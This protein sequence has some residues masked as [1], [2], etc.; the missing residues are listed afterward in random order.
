[1]KSK[2]FISLMA[3][4]ALFAFSACGTDEPV[5]DSSKLLQESI[6]NV[7][8]LKSFKYKADFKAE[9]TDSETKNKVNLDM[10]LNGAVS[11]QDASKTGTEFTVVAKVDDNSEN[12][13]F[14][15]SAKFFTEDIY[16]KL[17]ALPEVPNFPV[18]GLKGL[19]G[20]WWKI[21]A[22]D[23]GEV[24][25]VQK[26]EGIGVPY[27]KLDERGKKERDLILSSKFFKDIEYKSTENLEGLNVYEYTFVVDGNGVY[28]YVYELAKLDGQE[29]DAGL[30]EVKAM[31]TDAVVNGTIFVDVNSKTMVKMDLVLDAKK[32]K[33]SQ[34]NSMNLSLSLTDLNKPFN[35]ETPT[36]F[37]VFD[38]GKFLGS[39]LGSGMTSDVSV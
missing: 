8:N 32:S 1:M 9:V 5:P 30:K 20:K 12:Y 7:Y 16:L 22:A 37:E 4:S 26:M 29:K 11:G 35:V 14:D 6:Y 18:D 13:R 3:L 28:K 27:D 33:A 23:L 15:F 10:I 31:L 25:A 2:I 24:G 17:L 34:F 39:F 19:V 38:L 21:S 36:D